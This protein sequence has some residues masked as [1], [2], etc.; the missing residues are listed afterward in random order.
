VAGQAGQVAAALASRGFQITGTGDAASFG[1]TN[2]VIE[3]GTAAQLPAVKALSSQLSGAQPEQ[4]P[5][6]G[7][8]GLDL[9]VGSSFT[10][11]APAAHPASSG[12]PVTSLAHDYGGISANASCRSDAAAFAGPL[13]P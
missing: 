3:Y 9:I 11:L 5:S 12:R 8:G 7:P 4:V 13:S 10:A 2:S 1:Y 6:L